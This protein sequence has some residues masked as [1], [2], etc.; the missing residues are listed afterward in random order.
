MIENAIL[1]MSRLFKHT[2]DKLYLGPHCITALGLIIPDSKIHGTNMGPIWG[3]HDPGEPH[4]GP[5]NF[6]V[7]DVYL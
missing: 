4:V 6:A 5:M 2:K 3:Q 1:K 7:C